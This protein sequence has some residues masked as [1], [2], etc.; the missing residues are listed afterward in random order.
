MLATALVAGGVRW[1][2]SDEPTGS[3]AVVVAESPGPAAATGPGR[4][5]GR[6]DRANTRRPGAG[7]RGARAGRTAPARPARPARPPRPLPRSRATAIDIPYFRLA[8]PAVAV[9]LDRE[10]RLTVPPVDDPKVVGWYEGGATP[11]ERGTAVVVG[12]RD[13]RTGPAVFAA[14][15]RLPVGRLIEARRADGRVAVYTVD[16]VKTY[17]KARFPNKEVYGDRQRPELRLITCGGV[18]DRR[19]GY[20]GNIVVF[21]HLTETRGRARTT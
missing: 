10:R 11:G 8:A 19:K 21:A 13:T 6:T 3:G 17:E 18:Y 15:G 16:A 12:H 5:V 7:A 1:A 9:R 14:L 4:D 2:G 20:A